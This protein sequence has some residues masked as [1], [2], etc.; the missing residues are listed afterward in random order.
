M[1]QS[2]AP[3]RATT[4]AAGQ[5]AIHDTGR[6]SAQELTETLVAV[7]RYGLGGAIERTGLSRSAIYNRLNAVCDQLAVHGPIDAAIKLGWLR[8]PRTT[9]PPG[10]IGRVPRQEAPPTRIQ[11]VARQHAANITAAYLQNSLEPIGWQLPP[12]RTPEPP[13]P[14]GRQYTTT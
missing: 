12:K 14:A 4:E 6:I 2:A 10:P 8:F 3:M 13:G 5:P 9:L 11:R 7:I 1:D